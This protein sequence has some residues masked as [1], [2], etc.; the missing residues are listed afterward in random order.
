MEEG[1]L[2]GLG[3]TDQRGDV[4]GGEEGIGELF[5]GREGEV[6][7]GLAAEGDLLEVGGEEG[8]HDYIA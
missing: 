1:A 3:V 5:W 6:G 2:V 7:D 8:G 4:V